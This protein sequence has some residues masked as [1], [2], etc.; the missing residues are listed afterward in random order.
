MPFSSADHFLNNMNLTADRESFLARLDS[1]R[2]QG[3]AGERALAMYSAAIALA[4]DLAM[5]RAVEVGRRLSLT[6]NVL[7]EVVLQSYLF[8]GFP[9]M[10]TAAEN[11]SR[12]FPVESNEFELKA[13]SPAESRQ[14]FDRGLELC[15]KVYADK[16]EVLMNRV[17]AMAPDVFRW[18]IIEGYGKVLSRPSLDI[19][20]RE[21]SI[22]AFLMMENRVKQ[23]HSH[24][25]GALNVGASRELIH[26]VVDDIGSA[27]GDGYDSARDI[28]EQWGRD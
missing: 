19:I 27:A 1:F 21:L 22:I 23:L 6:A 16:Y 2:P 14:W 8:L 3:Q 11:L 20:S 7:Y 4:D 9:R 17:A 25:T 15:R 5:T 12:T 28:L 13:I 26:S 24:M 18:M 10:L